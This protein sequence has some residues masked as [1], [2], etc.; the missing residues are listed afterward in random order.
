M[1]F[2]SKSGEALN[3]VT[4]DIGVPNPRIPDN[5]GEQ[6]GP[7][8]EVHQIIYYCHIDGRTTEPYSPGH[9]KSKGMIKT[10]K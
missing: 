9:N 1:K 2:K 6:M 8:T 5:A 3:V 7:Q 4:R 10:L